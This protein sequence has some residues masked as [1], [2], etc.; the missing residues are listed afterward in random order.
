MT[1][2]WRA[3]GE[4]EPTKKTTFKDLT[5]DWYKEAVAWAEENAVVNGMSEGVFAP[6]GNVTRE[7]MVTIFHRMAGTPVGMEA[8]LTGIYDAQYP[9]S[10]S[11]GVWAKSALYW[12]VYNGIYCGTNSEEIGSYL[13]PKL[14]ATRA[15]IA[16]MI[17]RYLA[18]EN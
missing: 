3:M 7:Q 2:L 6:N 8:M 16:V 17:V 4:P 12:S 1:I 9:D 11:V 10:G 13:E 18:L 15:Q 14:P 5:Q